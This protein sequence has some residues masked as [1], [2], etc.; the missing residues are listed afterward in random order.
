MAN[1]M[2]R[3]MILTA[4]V[5]VPAASAG[6]Q[7]NGITIT[8]DTG[9]TGAAIEL[10]NGSTIAYYQTN[11]NAIHAL[12]GTGPPLTST[13]Y[14]DTVVLG[15]EIALPKTPL[16]V[17]NLNSNQFDGVSILPTPLE[18]LI[19]LANCTLFLSQIRLY[20]LSGHN[21]LRELSGSTGGSYTDGDLNSYN[22]V[23]ETGSEL[24]YALGATGKP[25]VGFESSNKLL[26]EAYWTGS[27][28]DLVTY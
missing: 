4:V 2:L 11:D 12:T 23:A 18:L 8:V 27:E 1:R 17:V 19:S 22:Y 25:R 26:S 13:T 24:L 5:L 7:A 16:A 14:Q 21:E 28:W 10:A 20:Y 3:I 6:A 15:A 9:S